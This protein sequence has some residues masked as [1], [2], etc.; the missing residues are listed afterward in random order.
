[1][2]RIHG[3]SLA[4]L[5]IGLS[6]LA[7]L[8]STAAP[9]LSGMIEN[10]ETTY[11]INQMTGAINHARS[12]AVFSHQTTV[13]CAGETDCSRTT[14]WNDSLLIFHDINNNSRIDNGESALRHEQLPDGYSWHWSSFRKL[15]QIIY[16][17]NGTTQA[18][19]G[20]LTLC[21]NGKPRR[22]IVISLS[23]RVRQQ[24]PRPEKTCS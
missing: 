6:I 11:A 19:N 4:E 14:T 15:T 9:A 1:M 2:K 16:E 20:T 7:I 18:A 21:K 13:L 23:G 5:L 17:Q 22:Q 10:N 12:A 8:L 24:A 3:H